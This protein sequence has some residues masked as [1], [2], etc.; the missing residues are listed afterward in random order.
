MGAIMST[1]RRL[2]LSDSSACC[3]MTLSA[4]ELERITASTEATRVAS[5][6]VA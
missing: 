5:A 2:I 4:R 1:S 6:F 3:S